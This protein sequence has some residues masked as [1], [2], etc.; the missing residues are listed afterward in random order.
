MVLVGSV[1]DKIAI[2]IDDIADTCGTI[3][4]AAE[5]FVLLSLFNSRQ[6]EGGWGHVRLCHL[7]AWFN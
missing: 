2:L 5:K 1:K 7:D 4:M 3:V 6:A